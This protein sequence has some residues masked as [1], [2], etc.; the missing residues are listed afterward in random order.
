M[1]DRYA[2]ALL[3]DVLAFWFVLRWL[4]TARM[5]LLVGRLLI[6]GMAVGALGAVADHHYVWAVC[7]AA[8][9]ALSGFCCDA[10]NAREGVG[11]PAASGPP[12]GRRG[13][14]SPESSWP[15]FANSGSG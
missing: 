7:F 9:C 15:R 4:P 12:A 13:G 5:T 3:L 1:P 8:S 10:G 2:A 14:M 6:V 11:G